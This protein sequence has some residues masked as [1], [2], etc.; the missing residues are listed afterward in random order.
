MSNRETSIQSNIKDV[1]SVQEQT[2][3]KVHHQFPE[4]VS[5]SEC[6]FGID[7]HITSI[8]IIA[9]VTILSNIYLLKLLRVLLI[10]KAL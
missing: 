3:W 5:I 6:R 7:M 1:S 9:D 8:I 4:T 10:F 2:K